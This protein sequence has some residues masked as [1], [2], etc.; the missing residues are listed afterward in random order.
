M[1]LVLLFVGVRVLCV[2]LFVFLPVGI[3]TYALAGSQRGLK[4]T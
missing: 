3:Y 1:A 4:A 2:A